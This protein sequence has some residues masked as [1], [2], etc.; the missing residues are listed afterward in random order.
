MIFNFVPL[1]SVAGEI[2]PNVERHYH[3]M[4]EPDE[5]GVPNIDWDAYLS[6]SYSGQCFVLTARD[7]GKLIGYAVYTISKNPRYKHLIEAT[8]NGI[9][10]EKPYRGRLGIKILKIADEYLEKLGVHE[11]SYIMGGRAEK[12]LSRHGYK[13]TY[14]VW[15]KKYGQ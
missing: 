4:S 11:T 12:L 1:H 8:G 3:E 6:A 2:A 5:Y 9:F 14:K 10:I 15:S 7:D 13:S